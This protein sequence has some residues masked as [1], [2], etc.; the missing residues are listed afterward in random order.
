[1]KQ[2]VDPTHQVRHNCKAHIADTQEPTLQKRLP[3]T[4]ASGTHPNKLTHTFSAGATKGRYTANMGLGKKWANV[5]S[6]S[7][8]VILFGLHIQLDIK[9]LA[10]E[11][12]ITFLSLF[13]SGLPGL[14]EH[15]IPVLRQPLNGIGLE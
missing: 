6:V 5:T 8:F 12:I 13:N 7:T 1:M 14:T 9:N 3:C 4:D 10:K 2:T 15:R 11:Y